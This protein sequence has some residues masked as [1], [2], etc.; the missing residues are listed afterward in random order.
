M[1]KIRMKLKTMLIFDVLFTIIAYALT[2]IVDW[3][4]G[5]ALLFYDASC[6]LEM[7]MEEFVNK[8]EKGNAAE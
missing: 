8:K 5:I 1:I 7:K 2:I 6:G 4:L 3:R